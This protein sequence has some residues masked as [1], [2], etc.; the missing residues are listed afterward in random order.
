MVCNEDKNLLISSGLVKRWGDIKF[1][2]N[3]LFGLKRGKNLVFKTLLE[4]PNRNLLSLST[5]SELHWWK[6]RWKYR[7][8]GYFQQLSL[9]LVAK[10]GE[11]IENT[12]YKQKSLLERLI[13]TP[14]STW[15]H[16]IAS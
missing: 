14:S 4:L 7:K 16:K 15:M 6:Q 11:D 10:V 9:L 5:L 8:D 1:C 2:K 13:T 12:N 3:T